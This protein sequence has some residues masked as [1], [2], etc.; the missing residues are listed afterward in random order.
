LEE[1]KKKKITI[2]IITSF[3]FF[4]LE[5][6]GEGCACTYVYVTEIETRY[7]GTVATS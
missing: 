5:R 4:C 1:K 3:F 2:T 7:L 6:G